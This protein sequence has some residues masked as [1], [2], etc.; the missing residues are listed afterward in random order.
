MAEQQQQRTDMWTLE[1]T[2]T[3]KDKKTKNEG[4]GAGGN[5][6]KRGDGRQNCKINE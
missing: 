5:T 6:A 3:E 1:K 4:K 2:E